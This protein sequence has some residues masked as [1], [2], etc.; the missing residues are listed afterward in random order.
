MSHGTSRIIGALR[1]A[2]MTLEATTL[3]L[4]ALAVSGAITAPYVLEA[5][6]HRAS[7]ATW[8]P[9][10]VAAFDAHDSQKPR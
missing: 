9:L 7:G 5:I 6:G 3:L 1:K 4:L 10:D 2:P 8:W